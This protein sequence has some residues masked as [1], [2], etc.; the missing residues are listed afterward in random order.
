MTPKYNVII[1]SNL[2]FLLRG[3]DN[4]AESCRDCKRELNLP[5]EQMKVPVVF[6]I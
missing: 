2:N 1:F 6:F 5:T 3:H 4:R